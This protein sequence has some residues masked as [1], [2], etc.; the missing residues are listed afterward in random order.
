MALAHLHTNINGHWC[1]KFSANRPFS[2]G[3]AQRRNV[4]ARAA[5]SLEACQP[6]DMVQAYSSTG[7]VET[8]QVMEPW[9]QQENSITLAWKGQLIKLRPSETGF[10]AEK[11]GA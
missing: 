1:L 11:T 6:L 3:R 9:N 2:V 8:F 5:Q 10:T 7:S 4:L